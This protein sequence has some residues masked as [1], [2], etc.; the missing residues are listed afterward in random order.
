V[1]RQQ[2]RFATAGREIFESHCASCHGLNGRGGERAPD[3]ISNPKVNQLPDRTLYQTISQGMPR[4]GMPSF[5]LALSAKDISA[6]VAF[7]RR[8]G[9]PGAASPLPG[10]PAR[11]KELFFGKAVCADC[12]MVKGRGGF[13]ASDLSGYGRGHSPS[14]IRDAVVHPKPASRSQSISA[15]TRDGREW[16]GIARNEDNFSI[17]VQDRQGNFHLLQKSDLVELKR[18]TRSLMPDDY[19]SRL[20]QTEL[21]DL[22]SYLAT[23]RSP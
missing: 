18:E 1:R 19:S 15:T 10:N 23:L 16:R 8:E 11:G 2:D 5:R 9:N 12:H 13:L 22:V 4:A 14:D 7:L 3:L 20:K 17:Q 6:V 21:D